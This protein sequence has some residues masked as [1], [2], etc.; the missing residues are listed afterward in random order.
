M[1]VSGTPEASF[2]RRREYDASRCEQ[3]FTQ[4]SRPGEGLI[5]LLDGAIIH[6]SNPVQITEHLS[7]VRLFQPWVSSSQAGH[8]PPLSPLW[9]TPCR[10]SEPVWH[11]SRRELIPVNTQTGHHPDQALYFPGTPMQYTPAK[12]RAASIRVSTQTA[13][14][15][16]HRANEGEF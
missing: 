14:Q 4:L 6:R 16:A 12:G 15:R 5:G 9:R 10:I 7:A 8:G 2:G 3:A 13:V 11:R 1:T